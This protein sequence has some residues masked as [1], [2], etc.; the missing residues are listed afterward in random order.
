MK[1]CNFDCEIIINKYIDINLN[2]ECNLLDLEEILNCP[3]ALD[4]KSSFLI[5]D[6]ARIKMTLT[7]N[8][9]YKWR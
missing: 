4:Y 3:N 6:D 7:L 1:Y 5:T 9:N 8:S 2:N